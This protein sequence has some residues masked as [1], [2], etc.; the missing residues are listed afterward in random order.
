M[1]MERPVCGGSAVGHLTGLA[2]VAEVV[3]YLF[4]QVS[5]Q[6]LSLCSLP[7]LRRDDF[8]INLPC[9]AL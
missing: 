1:V 2:V 4:R 8:L 3:T 7:H 5:I 9:Q 6:R